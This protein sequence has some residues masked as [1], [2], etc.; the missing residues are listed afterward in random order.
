MPKAVPVGAQG[1]SEHMGVATVVLGASD[2]EAVTEA[3]ELLWVNRID[4]KA[5]FEQRLDNRAVW[6]LNG[7]GDHRR[8]GSRRYQQPDTHLGKPGPA[9][10]K[11]SLAD[12]FAARIDQADLVSLAR[13]VDA[14]EPSRIVRHHF[15]SRLLPGHRDVRHSLY[16]RSQRNSPRTCITANPP[17]HASPQG[18]EA[19]GAMGSSRQAGPVRSVYNQTDLWTC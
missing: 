12:N 9:V 19:Q 15:A 1:I 5:A 4:Q 6:H 10:G 7:H 16:W 8:L 13:P 2:G 11:S 17:G 14:D 3:V 18:L